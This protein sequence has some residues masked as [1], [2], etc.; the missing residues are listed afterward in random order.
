MKKLIT[1]LTLSLA[2]LLCL[3]G[4]YMPGEAKNYSYAERPV[5]SILGDS[6]SSHKEYEALSYY[7]LDDSSGYNMDVKDTWWSKFAEDNNYNIGWAGGVGFSQ[8]SVADKEYIS[9]NNPERINSLSNRG[10]PDVIAVYGGTNDAI[11]PYDGDGEFSDATFRKRYNLLIKKLHQMYEGVKLILIAPGH[12]YEKAEY[13]STNYKIDGYD[14]SIEKIANANGDYF[15]DLRG[16]LEESENNY[17]SSYIHPNEDGM[18]KIADTV[19]EALSNARGNTGIDSIR[20]EQDYDHYIIKI[21]AYDKN[22]DNLRFRFRLTDNSTGK[23]I[24]NTEWSKDNC[25]LF[26]DVK[27]NTSYTAYSEIDNNGDG[28]AEAD[29]KV[30]LTGLNPDKKTGTTIYQ[31]VD[32]GS[33]YNF[34]YYVE[35][36][37]DLYNVFRNNPDAAI[38]HFVKCGM[39]EGRQ[40]CE[41]FDVKSYRNRYSGLRLTFGWEDL[42]KYY[43]HYIQYGKAEGRDASYCDTVLNPIHEFFGIDFSSVYDYEYYKSHHPDLYAA[44]GDNDIELL[45]HFFCCGMNEGRQAKENFNVFTYASNYPELFY[46]LGF[47]IP[48]YY[49]HYINYGRAE[50]RVAAI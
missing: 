16:V 31:G 36:H 50:G 42:P 48:E 37:P 6:I 26:Y 21:N 22:Y 14:K 33:V 20:A 43:M 7:G 35:N 17:D 19:A 11:G 9:L 39:N 29:K 25:Y 41:T 5:L 24:Y 34:N 1:T 4:I 28:R 13:V 47:N 45:K 3:W 46:F 12:F 23:V 18:Q 32:Y 49:Y 30:I 40:A 15:V 44:F 27:A 10:V 38:E 2:A 8:V